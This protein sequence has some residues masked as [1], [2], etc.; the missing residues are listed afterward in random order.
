MKSEPYL[1]SPGPALSDVIPLWELQF[2]L[3]K[4]LWLRQG[5]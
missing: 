1:M 5:K 2:G 4:A 3:Q